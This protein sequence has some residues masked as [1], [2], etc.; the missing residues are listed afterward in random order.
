MTNLKKVVSSTKSNID[1]K[2]IGFARHKNGKVYPIFEKEIKNYNNSIF[3]EQELDALN[4]N[5]SA[6]S[7]VVNDLLINDKE[8][9]NEVYQGRNL[10]EYTDNLSSALNK[11]EDYKGKVI[12]NA[13]LS[14]K[15][16]EKYQV[17]KTITEKSYT[18]TTK[19]GVYDDSMNT[20]FEIISKTGKDLRNYSR[21]DEYE[22]LFDKNTDFLT[23]DVQ[24]INEKTF[25]KLE[26]VDKKSP[27]SNESSIIEKELLNKSELAKKYMKRGYSKET[28]ERMAKQIINRRK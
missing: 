21:D 19:N 7:Y 13:D 15:D 24:K 14:E 28:A 3:T 9:D 8:L 6:I 12:R 18:A 20:Q 25:I 11:L 26:E 5:K 17:G 23:K 27:E 1:K 2:I 16:L 10:K 22:V 4:E